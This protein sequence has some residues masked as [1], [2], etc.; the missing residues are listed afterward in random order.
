MRVG[1]V[2]LFQI[3]FLVRG[4]LLLLGRPFPRLLGLFGRVPVGSLPGIIIWSFF[5][6]RS[7]L[8]EQA[9][10]VTSVPELGSKQQDR[11][12]LQRDLF[13]LASLRPLLLLFSF[14]VIRVNHSLTVRYI[15]KIPRHY[16]TS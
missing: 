10:I 13:A 7:P 5:A 9:L 8:P 1:V 14:I 4:L 11:E 6:H 16:F 2:P 15:K 12:T 3:N